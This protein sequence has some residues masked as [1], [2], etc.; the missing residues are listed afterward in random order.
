LASNADLTPPQTPGALA[1]APAQDLASAAGLA[2][3]ETLETLASDP[4]L[5][6]V[7]TRDRAPLKTLEMLAFMPGQVDDA[8]RFYRHHNCHRLGIFSQKKVN[9]GTSA[10]L[11][12]RGLFAGVPGKGGVGK[13]SWFGLVFFSVWKLRSPRGECFGFCVSFGLEV[14]MGLDHRTLHI[15]NSDAT[16]SVRS[17]KKS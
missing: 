3:L 4:G 17:I 13:S 14:V 6:V 2:R 12:M 16:G 10:S 9:R 11:K 7:S 15:C 1:S 8:N 5:E